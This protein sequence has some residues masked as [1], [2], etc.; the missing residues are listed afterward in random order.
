MFWK[1]VLAF[2][3]A[4]YLIKFG[5]SLYHDIRLKSVEDEIS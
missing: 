1:V 3:P 4:Q 2:N 5:L